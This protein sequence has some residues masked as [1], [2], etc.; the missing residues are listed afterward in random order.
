MA[1]LQFAQSILGLVASMVTT[2]IELQ[3]HARNAEPITWRARGSSTSA[4]AVVRI[5][6]GAR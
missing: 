4:P 5:R 6:L 2:G 1:L 3:R